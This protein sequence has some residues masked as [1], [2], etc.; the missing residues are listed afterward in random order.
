[1]AGLDA[2]ATYELNNLDQTG[3][4]TMRGRELM[5]GGLPVSLKKRPAAALIT[6]RRVK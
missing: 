4:A 1:L 5:D 2:D 3:T 6:Y